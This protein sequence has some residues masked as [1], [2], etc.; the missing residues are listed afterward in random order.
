MYDLLT[1]ETVFESS[2]FVAAPLA[3]LALVHSGAT[4]I[5]IDPLGGGLDYQRM[6]RDRQTGESLF[7]AGLNRGK[8][9]VCIDLSRDEGAELAAA[10]V[11]AELDGGGI[12]LT[13]LPQRAPLQY[14]VL[15]AR[16]ADVI[17]LQIQGNF[18]G[19]NAVDYIVNP[20]TGIPYLTGPDSRSHP[21]NSILPAWDIACGFQA[22]SVVLSMLYRRMREG[23]GGNASLALSDVAFSLLGHLGFLAEAVINGDREPTGNYLFGGFGR[24]FTTGDGHRIM[25]VGLTLRQWR[26]LVQALELETEIAQIEM[27]FG[28]SLVDEEVRFEHRERIATLVEERIAALRL[29]EIEDKFGSDVSWTK[30]QTVSELVTTDER[31]SPRNPIWENEQCGEDKLIPVPGAAFSLKDAVRKSPSAVPNLGGDTYAV[32][33]ERLGL[34]HSQLSSLSDRRIIAAPIGQKGTRE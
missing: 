4:V 14:E 24:D 34:S 3:G 23:V 5:R 8:Q 28:A 30:Y 16:R 32:L 21:V 31:M 11:T 9:S 25:V 15:R 13:N 19:S 6:P 26:R 22:A 10:M 18:D 12:F 20:A 17:R 1:G 29:S 27:D 2:A 33:S 7:W